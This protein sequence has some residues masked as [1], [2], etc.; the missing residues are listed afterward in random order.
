MTKWQKVSVICSLAGFMCLG[1]ISTQAAGQPA[2]SSKTLDEIVVESDRY[3]DSSVMPGGKTDRKIH[4]GIYGNT[5]Y[6]EVPAN[7]NSYTDKTIKQSYIPGRTLENTVSNNPSIM[8]GGAST[9]NNVELQIRGI[10][11]NTHDQLMD[12]IPGMMAMG[13]I[14]LNWVERI[15]TV[16]GPNVVVSGTGINQSVSGFI[17]Y[18]PKIA[19]DK[20]NLDISETYSSHR[21]F[22]HAIDWGKRFG[23]ENRWGVRINA[24]EYNGHTSFDN[25]KLKGKDF[26][27]H[28]DQKTS[29]S[30]TSFVYGFD[31]VENH[32]MPEVLNVSTNWGKTVTGLPSA[33]NVVENF[34][35][36]WSD[37]SHQRHVYTISHDQKLNDHVSFY[38]RGG[39]EKLTW[40]GYWDAKP[41]LLNDKGDYNFG[42]YGFGVDQDSRWSR[43]ALTGGFLFDFNT[44][45]VNHK[46]NF[47]YEYLSNAWYYLNYSHATQRSKPEGNIYTGQWALNNGA[48]KN[49]GGI[50]YLSSRVIDRSY[51][52]SDTISALDDRLKF[53][54]G[55]RR[56][57]I[58]TK[59]FS[60]SG[61]MT[62]HYNRTKTS[63]MYSVLYKTSPI[64]SIYASY[65]E[66]LS[67]TAPISGTE[68]EHDVF[69]PVET[70]QYEFGAKWDFKNWGTTLSYFHIKQPGVVVKNSDNYSVLDG[71]N[72][73]Q[74]IEWNISGKVLP[75]LT[76]TG[77]IMY[78][79]AKYK[80]TVTGVNDGKRVHGTPRFNATMALDWDTPVEGLEVNLRARYFGHSY[81]DTANQVKVPSWTRFDLGASYDTNVYSLPV[82]FAFNAYNLFDKK[83]WS[84]ATSSYADGMIMLNPGR[85]YILSA[86]IHL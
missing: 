50:W 77:G 81:A 21:L 47:G 16:A 37:L 36:S 66:G 25:E 29:S 48:P 13:I 52:V 12:G 31:S 1:G 43:R 23:D 3:N 65:S 49:L 71:E 41:V 4:F 14:P 62:K 74:G 40:P 7:I 9:N 20:P 78:L 58:E 53:I 30:K 60:S 2:D 27:I 70:K 61:A 19:K 24:E 51:V 33:K 67:T 6:M 76:L 56:Q 64:S 73:N 83:Y 10:R 15:D 17:N 79:D 46:V 18:V 8:M 72:R 80:N 22:T 5:D 84:T 45:S 28:V 82:T 85:T 69:A 63:P 86:T 68:N 57:T 34:M 32:G 75:R 39:Y 42:K 11:F 54:I 55:A 44:G 38:L 35:P 59:G 26:Y